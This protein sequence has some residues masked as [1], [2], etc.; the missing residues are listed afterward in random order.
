MFNKT[1]LEHIVIALLI[2][3]A[4]WSLVGLEAAGLFAVA[5][6]IG[7]EYAQVEYKVRDRTG[8]SLTNMMP[9]HVM[10]LK[11]WSAD[12]VLDWVCPA[13]ACGILWLLFASS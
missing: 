4:L 6:F 2:Q 9:W 7:R 5:I 10:K 8:R 11:Y 1:H 12:A 13:I 3:L